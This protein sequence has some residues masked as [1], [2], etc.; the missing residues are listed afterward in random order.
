MSSF[1][2]YNNG[3]VFCPEAGK[4]QDFSSAKPFT[5]LVLERRNEKSQKNLNQECAPDKGIP[6]AAGVQ[7]VSS[8]RY[9]EDD[10]IQV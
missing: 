4:E 2:I 9:N 8:E 5:T 1:I 7:G 6:P 10:Q 3:G